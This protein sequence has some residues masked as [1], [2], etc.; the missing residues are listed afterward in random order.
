MYNLSK[1]LKFVCHLSVNL[2]ILIN[3][4]A[5]TGCR[6]DQYLRVKPMWTDFQRN[7][8]NDIGMK[9]INA[10]FRYIKM[11]PYQLLL[12]NK[13]QILNSSLFWICFFSRIEQNFSLSYA[14]SYIFLTH[15]FFYIRER[16]RI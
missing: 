6:I 3:I 10:T 4:F 8:I 1:M 5:K 2:H 14:H 9:S 15:R 16:I 11:H 13:Y 7:S 12:V